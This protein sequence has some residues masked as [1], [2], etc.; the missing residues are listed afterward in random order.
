M[1]IGSGYGCGFWA[2]GLGG[3]MSIGSGYGC[4]FW[5]ISLGGGYNVDFSVSAAD[6]NCGILVGIGIILLVA[7]VHVGIVV[8]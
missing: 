4:G 7:S 8:C 2:I 6:Y 1:S 5:A 3:S